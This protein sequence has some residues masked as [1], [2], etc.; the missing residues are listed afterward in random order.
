MRSISIEQ[1]LRAA[2]QFELGGIIVGCNV[3]GSGHINGTNLITVKKPDGQTVRYILQ[4]INGDVFPKPEHVINNIA[5]VTEHLHKKGLDGRRVLNMIPAR[6]GKLRYWDASGLCFRMYNF[7]ENS[8]CLDKVESPEDFYQS[9][10]AF[11]EFQ[12]HLT[13]F[14]VWQLHETLADFH[15]TP[16][17]FEAFLNAVA[18]DRC[19]RVATVQNEIDF[20]QKR[21]EFC[22]VLYKAHEEGRLPLRVTH[23]DTK[24]NN[25]MLDAETR[26]ALC[27]IDLDTVM[28]GFS[29][30]DFGDAIRFGASTAAED[31][32]DL[33]KVSLDM[34]LF[35]AYTEGFLEGCGGM[36]GAEE[37]RLLPEGAK[38]MTFEC[39]MRFL[40]DYLQGD[41][42]FKT[43]YEGHNLDRCRT[44]SKLVECM[45]EH[46]WDMKTCVEKYVNQ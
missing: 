26:K 22:S 4:V 9:G 15:N 6:D 11:G 18:Q 39:G 35:E 38:M 32:R 3:Y 30:N 14:P 24:L 40:T 1:V 5:K 28:P 12:R 25:V 46:W 8:V 43:S 17:R 16:K 45:E 21:M 27:V 36:L 44:Q 7:I 13:D 37:I 20:V 23:N 31:E 41:T 42:Y 29:V 34:S 19:G 33:S 2:A 10:Y